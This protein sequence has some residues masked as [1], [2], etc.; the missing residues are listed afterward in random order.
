MAL[1]WILWRDF[2]EVRQWDNEYRAECWN[3]QPQ[4]VRLPLDDGE[5]SRA[6]RGYVVAQLKPTSSLIFE[7]QG[8]ANLLK[9]GQYAAGRSPAAAKAELWEALADSRLVAEGIPDSGGARI[10]VPAR[11]W[12]DLENVTDDRVED[13]YFRYRHRPLGRAYIDIVWRRDDLLRLWP[14]G[15]GPEAEVQ[16][17][18]VRRQATAADAAAF[19][20]WVNDTLKSGASPPTRKDAEHWAAGR[21]IGVEWARA[22]HS[23][24]PADKKLGRGETPTRRRSNRQ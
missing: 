6:V 3:W 17:K 2:S 15:E 21:Y 23:A 10:E 4:N 18:P 9:D 7:L 1:S 19:S 12:T 8:T 16:V 13:E 11:E 24:L 22:Q 5:S 14:E 20:E